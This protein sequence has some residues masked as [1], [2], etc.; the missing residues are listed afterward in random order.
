MYC[1]QDH[2]IHEEIEAQAEKVIAKIWEMAN[3]Q[4]KMDT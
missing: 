2:I 1:N 4:A 3:G